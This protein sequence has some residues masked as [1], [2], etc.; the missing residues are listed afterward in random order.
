MNSTKTTFKNTA[1]MAGV[2][3]ACLCV[4][5]AVADAIGPVF[6][7]NARIAIMVHQKVMP[8]KTFGK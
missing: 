7:A 1:I 2:A 8:V 3:V 6:K 5:S 4:G